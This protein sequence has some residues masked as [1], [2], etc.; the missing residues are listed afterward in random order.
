MTCMYAPPHVTHDMQV[1]SSCTMYI[2]IYVHIICPPPLLTRMYP[3]PLLTC[4]RP[5]PLLTRM[6]PPPLLTHISAAEALEH[7]S[8]LLHH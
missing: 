1:S 4:M 6:Y 5:P 2:F 7:A 3:P 8:T